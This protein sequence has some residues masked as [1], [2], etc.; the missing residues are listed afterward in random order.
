[1]REGI[2]GRSRAIAFG[3]LVAVALAA[4][5]AVSANTTGGGGGAGATVNVVAVTFANKLVVDVTLDIT[6]QPFVQFD[7]SGVPTGVTTTSGTIVGNVSLMQA[8]G[9]TIAHASGSINPPTQ[10]G[11]A[12]TCD[13]STFRVT[14][15]V[16][17]QDLPLRRGAAVVTAEIAMYPTVPCCDSWSVDSINLGP[18]SVKIG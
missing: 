7:W 4:P 2:R 10:N 1:M 9:R 15:P 8:Q 5:G 18:T 6:C 14:V 3:A 13:G 16:V 17:A 12:V 11:P